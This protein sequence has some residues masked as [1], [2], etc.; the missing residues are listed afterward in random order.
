MSR[1]RSFAVLLGVIIA[2]AA[3]ALV[4]TRVVPSAAPHIPAGRV[5][6]GQVQLKVY[7]TGELRA[8]RSTQVVAPPVLALVPSVLTA[9]VC[10]GVLTPGN[11]E[12]PVD[13]QSGKRAKASGEASALSQK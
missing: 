7:T 8:A 9:S 5:R 10:T 3:L 6:K 12:T 1:R 11:G 13:V 2:V 4:W